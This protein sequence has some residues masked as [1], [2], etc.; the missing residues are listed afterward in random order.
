MPFDLFPNLQTFFQT[1]P[2]HHQ[3]R[4]LTL[5]SG[6]HTVKRVKWDNEI[7]LNKLVQ[8]EK[9]EEKNKGTGEENEEEENEEDEEDSDDNDYTTKVNMLMT[10]KL[11]SMM[12]S[13]MRMMT[14]FIEFASHCSTTWLHVVYFC[15]QHKL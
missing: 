7:D 6:Q 12:R 10:M 4:R 15:L 14:G 13:R 1:S 9:L 5:P 8:F 3:D 11:T 2:Y